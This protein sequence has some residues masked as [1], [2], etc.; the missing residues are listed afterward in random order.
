METGGAERA[1]YAELAI[2]HDVPVEDDRGRKRSTVRSR[3]LVRLVS[4]WRTRRR[5][6]SGKEN[7]CTP[8]HDRLS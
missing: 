2:G 5:E 8:A 7:D 3:Q 4:G 6:M 1:T